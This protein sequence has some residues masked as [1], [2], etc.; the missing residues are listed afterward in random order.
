VN[1][2]LMICGFYIIILCGEIHETRV[3]FKY[4]LTLVYTVHQ[5][6]ICLL[7]YAVMAYGGYLLFQQVNQ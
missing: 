5:L 6:I 4:K 7:G 2:L 3:K 1:I